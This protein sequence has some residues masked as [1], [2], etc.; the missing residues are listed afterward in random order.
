MLCCSHGFE[1][2]AQRKILI[3]HGTWL[4]VERTQLGQ[5]KTSRRVFEFKRPRTRKLHKRHTT[6]IKA[7]K[8]MKL[9]VLKLFQ[10]TTHGSWKTNSNNLDSV[11]LQ[12]LEWDETRADTPVSISWDWDLVLWES[13]RVWR[14]STEQLKTVLSQSWENCKAARRANFPR[15]FTREFAPCKNWTSR[16]KN[17]FHWNTEEKLVL[18]N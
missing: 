12:S 10:K 13:A 16:R 2:V 11:W 15:T 7:W 8:Q 9:T 5:Q 18:E 4:V 6:Q 3:C 14:Y 17:E 1:R